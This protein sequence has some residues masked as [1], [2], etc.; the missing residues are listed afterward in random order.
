MMFPCG[1]N[2]IMLSISYA[3]IDA[4]VTSIPPEIFINICQDLTPIDLITLSSVCK[5]FYWYLCSKNSIT[6]QEIWK[7]SRKKFLPFAQLPPP[8]G[9]DER[10]YVRL[11][12]ERGCQFCGRSRVRRVYWAFKFRCCKNCLENRTMRF[13][14]IKRGILGSLHISDEILSGLPYITGLYKGSLDKSLKN[15]PA[16]LYLIS[17]VSS[18]Y[19]E[20]IKLQQKN[21]QQLLKDWLEKKK[22]E[23]EKLMEDAIAHE[24]EHEKECLKKTEENGKKRDDRATTIE[25]MIRKEKNFYGFPRFKI[26]IVEQCVTYTKATMSNSTRPFTERAWIGL[27][28]KLIPEYDH[29]VISQRNKRQINERHLCHDVAFQ[30]RQMDIPVFLFESSLIK[31]LPWLPSFRDPPFTNNDPRILWDEDFLQ[32]IF[33]PR[34]RQQ[35]IE[36]KNNPLPISTV[37]GAFLHGGLANKRIFALQNHKVRMINDEMMIKVLPEMIDNASL[38]QLIPRNKPEIFFAAGFNCNLI[39]NL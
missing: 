19:Q 34:L 39:V 24:D 32:S 14:Q 10:S 15:R 30:T 28:K 38:N 21:D 29:M 5:K 13:D 16:N 17:D 6:T 22:I 3:N 31:Y 23:G 7:N 35:A 9:M 1:E 11:L 33:I 4:I 2:L 18:A 27:K 36:L 20:F 26:S 37:C 12:T 25:K 8:Q